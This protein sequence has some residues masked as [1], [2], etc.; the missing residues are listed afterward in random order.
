MENVRRKDALQ[1]SDA[2]PSYLSALIE[3]SLG[4]AESKVPIHSGITGRY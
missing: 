2:V 1:I 4:S 3:I